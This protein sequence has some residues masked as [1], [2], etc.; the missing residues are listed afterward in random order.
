[1]AIYRCLL[2]I[3]AGMDYL[4]SIGV[5]H[6][7]DLLNTIAEMRSL[8]SPYLSLHSLPISQPVNQSK[9]E[10][11]YLESDTGKRCCNG[12]K[13]GTDMTCAAGDLKGGN[14]LMKST[15]MYDDPRGFVCKIGD[16]G[17]SRVLE[18]NSTHISTNTYGVQRTPLTSLASA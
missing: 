16:F 2:D 17:L 5:L 8:S 12:S 3:A 6:G 18:H 14:V 7:E 15:S 10:A 11:S 1:M 13:L 4:H 9:G